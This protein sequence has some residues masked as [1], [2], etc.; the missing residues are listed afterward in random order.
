MY[1]LC[2]TE[3]SARRQMEIEE[4]LLAVMQQRRYEE[5]SVSELCQKLNVPRKSFYRY[6]GSKEDALLGLLDHRLMGYETQYNG[7][8]T[9]PQ[10]G[11]TLRL[12]WFFE[13]WKTQKDLLDALEHSG[14]SGILVQRA[15]HNSQRAEIF[16]NAPENY[17][18]ADLEMSTGFIVCGLMSIVLQW[19]HD[20]YRRRPREMAET[21]YKMLSRPMVPWIEI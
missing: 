10:R 14:L 11:I 2:K 12:T 7:K 4:G 20:G 8:Q 5:I 1:K 21:A 16:N 6:F 13:F 19:H 17:S 18:K 9:V 15:I 3:Q